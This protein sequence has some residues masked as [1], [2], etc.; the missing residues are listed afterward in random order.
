MKRHMAHVVLASFAFAGFD[1]AQTTTVPGAQR[2]G[3]ERPPFDKTARSCA[4]GVTDG[5]SSSG[6]RP[7]R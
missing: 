3:L 1:R 4:T 2:H 6:M 7:P 5:P